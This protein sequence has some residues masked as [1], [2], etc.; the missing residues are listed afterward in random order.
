MPLR[1]SLDTDMEE[2]AARALCTELMV[3]RV[4]PGVNGVVAVSEELFDGPHWLTVA[5][6][7]ARHVPSQHRVFRFGEEISALEE[8][9]PPRT[10]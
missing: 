4:K 7:E 6:H 5:L 10:L 9:K 3:E 2:S 8:L 1:R